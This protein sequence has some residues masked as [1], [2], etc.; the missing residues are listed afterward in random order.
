MEAVSPSQAAL[1]A[2]RHRHTHTLACGS[3]QKVL[4]GFLT[5]VTLGPGLG[6]QEGRR[7]GVLEEG[8][9]ISPHTR[10]LLQQFLPPPQ[11]PRGLL[12]PH[13]PISPSSEQE[14]GEWIFLASLP[15]TFRSRRPGVKLSEC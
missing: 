1:D 4:E 12:G 13:S 7:R 10:S 11:G 15:L 2:Y 5:E 9:L 6:V 3:S 14:G 8:L